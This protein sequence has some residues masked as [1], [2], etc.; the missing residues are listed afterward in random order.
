MSTEI[1]TSFSPAGADLYG[2]RCV[3]SVTAHWP[4]PCVVYADAPIEFPGVTVRFTAAIPRWQDTQVLLPESRPDAPLTGTDK[5]TRKPTNYIWNAK[6]FAVKPFV[7]LDA[8][9]RLG[10]GVLV[11]LD[12]DTVTTSDVPHSV[13]PGLLDGVDVAILGRGR[14][15]PETGFVA[16]RVPEALP[17]LRWCVDA[18]RFGE[19]LSLADGWTDCHVLRAGLAATAV[20]VRDLTSLA[21]A[22]AWRSHV[23][24]FA[25]SPLGPYVQH[26][27]GPARKADAA[28]QGPA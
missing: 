26:L 21:Y 16:F 2:R 6:R 12:G 17:L 4:Y 14:M 15:H 7:W 20:R 11:W 3:F 27:K 8:A 1:I 5:W 24:A 19:C 10:D 9:E 13:I 25:L 23:D 28:G 22:G 18:Y